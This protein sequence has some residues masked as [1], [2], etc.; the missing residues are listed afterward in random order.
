MRVDY[1]PGAMTFSVNPE[2]CRQLLA[3]GSLEAVARTPNHQA[4]EC[5]LLLSPED[6]P[7]L[8]LDHEVL[9]CRLP[10]QAIAEHAALQYPDNLCFVMAPPGG[11]ELSLVLSVR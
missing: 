11:G 7:H 5:E 2:E 4:F 3:G 6:S 10:A 8:C 1:L 9:S